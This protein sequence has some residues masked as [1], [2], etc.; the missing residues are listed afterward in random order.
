[1]ITPLPSFKNYKQLKAKTYKPEILVST[2]FVQILDIDEMVNTWRCSTYA[3]S[4]WQVQQ[5][6]SCKR[7]RPSGMRILLENSLMG[8]L[9]NGVD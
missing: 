8:D 1:M 4:L 6:Q 3:Y 7:R 5:S 9:P 2:W